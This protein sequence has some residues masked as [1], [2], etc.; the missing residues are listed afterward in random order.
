MFKGIDATPLKVFHQPQLQ[1]R[2][3]DDAHLAVK[4][5]KTARMKEKGGSLS[6]K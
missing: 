6:K 4:T 2:E 1:G 5:P 3:G